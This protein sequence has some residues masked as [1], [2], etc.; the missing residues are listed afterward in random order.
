MSR[1]LLSVT[2]T[3]AGLACCSASSVTAGPCGSRRQPPDDAAPRP[4]GPAPARPRSDDRIPDA[5]GS[6]HTVSKAA[7]PA[8]PAAS[9]RAYTGTA[10]TTLYGTVQ[11]K[12][13]VVGTKITNV[14][15]AADLDGPSPDRRGRIPLQRDTGRAERPD[16]RGLRRV[17]HECGLRGVPAERPRPGPRLAAPS[18]PR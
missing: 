17:V 3:I 10:V 9:T 14:S 7:A 18:W 2:A 16:R 4:P 15:F 8:A 6:A 11:V 1:I 13:T 5:A 12:V